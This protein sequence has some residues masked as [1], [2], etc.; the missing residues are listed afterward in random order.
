MFGP[1][2]SAGAVVQRCHGPPSTT[3]C[4]QLP[5][6]AP[7]RPP[8]PCPPSFF[9]VFSPL[10]SPR[11]VSVREGW[12]GGWGIP[13]VEPVPAPFPLCSHLAPA[14][15]PTWSCTPHSH[16]CKH[17]GFVIFSPKSSAALSRA[18]PQAGSYCSQQS[19]PGAGSFSPGLQPPSLF[20]YTAAAWWGRGTM[21]KA[22][23]T[24][25][26]SQPYFKTYFNKHLQQTKLEK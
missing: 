14:S 3:Q 15:S 17:S 6:K 1:L 11:F 7:Q 26:L 2:G 5:L 10:T 18:G 24:G 25:T 4:P 23:V 16:F 19:A 12:A 22:S 20:P 21:D 9:R 8:A 13:N